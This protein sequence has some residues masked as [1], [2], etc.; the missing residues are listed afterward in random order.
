MDD[1]HDLLH[2]CADDDLDDDD[3]NPNADFWGGVGEDEEEEIPVPEAETQLEAGDICG[4][5]VESLDDLR[6]DD[7]LGDGVYMLCEDP[8]AGHC[9]TAAKRE[10]LYDDENEQMDDNDEYEKEKADDNDGNGTTNG[11]RRVTG[12]SNPPCDEAGTGQYSNGVK[13][14]PAAADHEEDRVLKR[15]SGAIAAQ[16]KRGTKST[17]KKTK[18]T[19]SNDHS[20]TVTV[21][22]NQTTPAP[23]V[24]DVQKRDMLKSRKFNSLMLNGLLPAAVQDEY[25][26]IMSQK[27]KNGYPFRKNMTELVEGVMVRDSVNRLTMDE[28]SAYCVNLAS[29]R[30]QRKL[31]EQFDVLVWEEAIVRCGNEA[32]LLSCIARK[33]CFKRGSGDKP[34][35]LWPKVAISRETAWVQE[36]HFQRRDHIDADVFKGVADEFKNLADDGFGDLA[37]FINSTNAAGSSTDPPKFKSG[38]PALLDGTIASP[39]VKGPP[40][41]ENFFAAEVDDIDNARNDLSEQIVQLNKTDK[42][43]DALLEKATNAGGDNPRLERAADELLTSQDTAQDKQHQANKLYKFRKNKDGTAATAM[44]FKKAAADIRDQISIMIADTKAV[45]AFLPKVGKANA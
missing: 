42:L 1:M 9:L 22:G 2:T 38:F 44:D 21:A 41:E 24:N 4:D 43:V 16:P 18:S 7:V 6:D 19:P 11:N 33:K 20:N 34:D 45:R 13:R 29:K 27:G 37:A 12:K 5:W 31:L 14:R 36:E 10:K 15:P 25:N 8:T 28:T 35:I 39:P 30:H 40:H 32:A 17:A 23:D 3:Y 26:K